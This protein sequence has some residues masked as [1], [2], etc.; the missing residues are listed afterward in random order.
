MKRGRKPEQVD[1]KFARGTFQPH[2]D[3]NKIQVIKNTDPP[4]FP[5]PVEADD[6]GTV[7]ES[8]T[9]AAQIVWNETIG[10]VMAVGVCEP[11]SA[12]F[13][14][15]CGMEALS[16]AQL[17]RGRPIPTALMTALRQ[18]EELMGIAGPKSRIGR[19]PDGK[20]AN[21]FSNNGRR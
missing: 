8:L 20:F 21:P 2:R 14:R 9:P 17:S 5:D 1:I 3:A 12:F 18:M 16:R 11:D 6:D 4:E 10:R 19:V 13:A 7:L 15:Y